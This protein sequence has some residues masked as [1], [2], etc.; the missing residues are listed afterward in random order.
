M[1]YRRKKNIAV[2]CKKRLKLLK[3][4]DF[5]QDLVSVTAGGPRSPRGHM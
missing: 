3:V 1:T 5:I 4:V 2:Q